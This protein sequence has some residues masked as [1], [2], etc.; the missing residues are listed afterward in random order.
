[1]LIYFLFG[2]GV[3]AGSLC[4]FVFLVW[5]QVYPSF[6]LGG[7]RGF[8]PRLC[9][10]FGVLFPFVFKSYMLQFRLR[11]MR[12]HL[13]RFVYL[14]SSFLVCFHRAA[15]GRKTCVEICEAK[16]KE[17]CCSGDRARAAGSQAKDTYL[18][19]PTTRS[20]ASVCSK[21]C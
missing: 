21:S 18:L 1:M 9:F 8:A 4:M 2:C 17:V 11:C 20:T 6:L 7:V 3:G 15:G 19:L 5:C 14:C 16:E 10:G 12:L 13:L